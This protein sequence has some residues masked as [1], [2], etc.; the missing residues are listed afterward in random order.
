LPLSLKA[1]DFIPDALLVSSRAGLKAKRWE[2]AV[3]SIKY[4]GV[5]QKDAMM[6]FTRRRPESRSSSSSLE[7]QSLIS[8]G[9]WEPEHRCYRRRKP[10][11]SGLEEAEDPQPQQQ[12]ESRALAPNDLDQLKALW[13]RKH[14]IREAVQVPQVLCKHHHRCL[15]RCP[16]LSKDEKNECYRG[17]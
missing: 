12:V 10:E 1:S 14:K 15:K 11:S 17:V 16:G 6:K 2:L 9:G 4:E 7:A 13:Q 5:N 8:S 3:E